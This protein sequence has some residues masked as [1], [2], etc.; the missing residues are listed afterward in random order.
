MNK[1]SEA[2]QAVIAAMRDGFEAEPLID[3]SH[4]EPNITV[5]VNGKRYRAYMSDEFEDDYPQMKAACD[6]ML[7]GLGEALSL[8]ATGSVLITT[9]GLKEHSGADF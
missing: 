4:G 9:T 1:I 7:G 2:T 5:R 3:E 8:S 6:Q